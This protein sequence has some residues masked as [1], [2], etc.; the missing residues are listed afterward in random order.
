MPTAYI[1]LGTNLPSSAGPP[2]QTLACAADRLAESGLVTARSPLYSTEPVGLAN[3][4][5]F[6]NA[7]IALETDLTPR[8]LL[9]A[10]MG[11]EHEYG[12]DRSTS[13]AN[14]PRTLDLDI[15]FYGDFVLSEAGLD[16]P[17]PRIAQRA[18]VLVP[19]NDIAPALRDPRSGATVQE[20]LK[21]LR[22]AAP[23]TIDHAIVETQSDSWLAGV[24]NPARG[25]N[26]GPDA[27]RAGTNPDHG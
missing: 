10:L 23:Q 4:P 26:P 21:A 18:F 24:G 14:G 22:Q 16:I 5:R 25:F 8:E 3:Q 9:E 2:E 13:V 6:L 20:L 7:V 12:R 27:A 17:H 11:I 15:L 1:A 19:L